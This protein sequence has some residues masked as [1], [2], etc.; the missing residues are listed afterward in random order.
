MLSQG[1]EQPKQIGFASNLEIEVAREISFSISLAK[2]GVSRDLRLA[3]Y[4][5]GSVTTAALFRPGR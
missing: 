4:R 3:S 2:T 1:I 5:L